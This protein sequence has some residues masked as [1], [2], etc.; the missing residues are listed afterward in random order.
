M[1]KEC[2][3]LLSVIKM[4]KKILLSIVCILLVGILIIIIS[5]ANYQKELNK[6]KNE[7]LNLPENFTYTAHTGCVNTEDNSLEAIEI[8]AKYGAQ[9]VEF[10]LNFL[11][12]GT[13]ILAHDEP[14]GDEITLDM[15]FKKVSEY[16]NLKINVDVKSVQNLKAVVDLAQKH[17][18]LNRIFYTGIELKDVETVKKDSPEVPYYLNFN[19]DKPQ[20]QTPEYLQSLVEGVKG[21]G[22]IGINFNKDNATKELVDTFHENGLLVSIWTVNN[23]KEMYEILHLSPDN[24][25]TRQPDKI[26][27]ILN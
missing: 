27:E 7:P 11:K 20:N 8:G 12:D 21:C 23:E 14:K 15:A 22:A 9:I 26:K 16:E 6:L 2:G 25:T 3:I 19:V 13:P 1:K 10:D 5:A 24:I 17:G 4:K 18:I